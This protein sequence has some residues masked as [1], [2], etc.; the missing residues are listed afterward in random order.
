MDNFQCI[1]SQRIKPNFNKTNNPILPTNISLIRELMENNEKDLIISNQKTY[2]YQLELKEKEFD[3][4][5]QKFLELQN[6]YEN[7]DRYKN[8]LEL[9][10]KQKD[11]NYNRDISIL[12]ADN[13][14]SQ[15]KQNEILIMN[16][17]LIGENEYLKREIEIKN[18]EIQ[19]LNQRL[20][21]LLNELN[22]SKEN[23]LKFS[24]ENEELNNMK[25]Y[26]KNEIEK[27]LEDNH[28]LYDLCQELNFSLK[29]AEK[30][31]ENLKLIIDDSNIK[32][33][34]QD[35]NIK[36]S[37]EENNKMKRNIEDMSDKI[38]EYE[39][40]NANL[41][42]NLL[43]EKNE[44]K[45]LNDLLLQK[46]NQIKSLNANYEDILNKYNNLNNELI[47][48]SNGIEKYINNCKILKEQNNQLM[49]EM[50]NIIS[51][52]KKARNI[53]NRKEKI[54][55]LILDNKSILQECMKN[56]NLINEE[57]INQ[58]SS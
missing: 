8:Q 32:L 7:L 41:K 58:N 14:S 17:K 16:K 48:K 6:E 25:L 13:E 56:I 3:N 23:Y 51:F 5:N 20:N 49:N 36:Y 15:L 53:L 22:I 31:K 34:S 46:E 24:K 35:E 21:D 38:F 33:N 9:E 37:N 2:I 19:R 11:N 43:N 1:R 27:L 4:L 30:E 40:E 54:K 18:K 47:D 39:K 28:K 42:M 57:N 12:R 44:N 45:N 52:N 26:D 29:E 50:N 55:N 10:I